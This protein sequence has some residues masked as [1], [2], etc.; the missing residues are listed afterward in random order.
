[1]K[2][3]RLGDVL[4]VKRGM[5]LPGEN[6]AIEGQYKRLTLGN[7]NYPGGGFKENNSKA[8]IYYV[9]EVREEFILK[10]GDIITPLTEQVPGLLGS[11]AFIP[12]SDLYI[13][14]GDVGLVLPDETKI[15]KSYV[16]YLLSSQI[17]KK[18]LASSAQ[19]TKIR[20]TSPDKIMECIAW[21]PDL[22][23]Q[24]R[25]GSLL[26]SIDLAI[27][28][29]KRINDNLEAQAKLLFD[30]WFVKDGGSKTEDAKDEVLGNV[31][32]VVKKTFNP[33]KE[34]EIQLEHYSIPAF[35]AGKFPV[36]ESSLSIKSNKYIV[37]SDCFMISKL[38]PTTKRVW[39]PYCLTN[40]AVCSTEFIV[41]KAKE[42]EYTDFLYSLVN[43]DAFSEHLCNH[44]TGST[45]SRQRTNP[46]DALKFVFKLPTEA[47]IA[48][49]SSIAAPIYEQ[50]RTNAIENNSLKQLRD[51][52][53]PLLM[54]GQISIGD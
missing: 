32:S 33:E 2:K 3:I 30:E 14:S 41:F 44:V 48:E 11:T 6:Y 36:F 12:T 1:M 42:R 46:E 15:D 23:S 10:E 37:D 47:V 16:F 13:Q 29:N 20:H 39:R 49:F 50:I 53:L 8:D 35:D 5:S 4:R 38:N 27:D 17:I 45:G 21:I 18:Q 34:P 52:L 22:S 25:I 7:F 24:R 51:Y 26:R 9:G 31:V 40:H 54:S 43:C 28:A 19:Q